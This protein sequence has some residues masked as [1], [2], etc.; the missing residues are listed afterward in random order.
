MFRDRH[1]PDRHARRERRSGP[2]RGQ[3]R[4]DRQGVPRYPGAR[5]A[6]A[7]GRTRRPLRG[8]SQ[9]RCGRALPRRRERRGKARHPWV[10]WSKLLGGGGS[11]VAL[12]KGD[13]T[14][15]P[16]P[17][18]LRHLLD[19][20]KRGID[21]ALLDLE[22]Q[23]IELIKFNLFDNSDLPAIRER[24]RQRRRRARAQGLEG[25]AA[26]ARRIRTIRDV[27]GADGTQVCT[28]EL[29][30]VR[31]LTGICNDIR[32]PRDGLDRAAVRAQRAVR[33]DLPGSRPQ[34]N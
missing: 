11:I 25:D 19:R 2:G 21:G 23:R 27:G 9:L 34:R 33:G 3:R 5:A 22:Y 12:G 30:R 26:A 13:S 18:L 8:Q 28:G 7:R 29:I 24:P 15:L 1:G 10:D 31:T 6:P 17:P 32:N 14:L 16:I 4:R 20:N